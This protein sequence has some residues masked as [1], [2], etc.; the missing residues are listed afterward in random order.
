MAELI[1]PT[2]LRIQLAAERKKKH[3]TLFLFDGE[4]CAAVR[5]YAIVAP[6]SQHDLYWDVPTTGTSTWTH[7][8]YHIQ[9]SCRRGDRAAVLPG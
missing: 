6:D 9:V 3:K 4:L 2:C 5:R 7:D 1:I 8:F